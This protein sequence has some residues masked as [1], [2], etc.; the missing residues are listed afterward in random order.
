MERLSWGVNV[1]LVECYEISGPH[2]SVLFFLSGRFSN[3][4]SSGPKFSAKR[5]R[6]QLPAG[7]V[8]I[9]TFTGLDYNQRTIQRVLVFED[10]GIRNR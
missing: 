9:Q 2:F 3:D 7:D 10:C 4:M 6:L 5:G 1:K 8:T